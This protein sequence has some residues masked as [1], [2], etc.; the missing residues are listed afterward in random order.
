MRRNGGLSILYNPLIS[1]I[2]N[3]RP[4][5]TARFRTM[6][7]SALCI[8]SGLSPSKIYIFSHSI[9]LIFILDDMMKK[10]KRE[11]DHRE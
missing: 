4:L 10:V 3:F 5:N 1:W 8:D 9:F 7:Y 2:P 6:Q 11:K